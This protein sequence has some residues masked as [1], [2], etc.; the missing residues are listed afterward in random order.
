VRESERE[1]AR[2][3][4]RESQHSACTPHD[5]HGST[6]QAMAQQL[7]DLHIK[8]VWTQDDGTPP[9]FVNQLLFRV[10]TVSIIRIDNVI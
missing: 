6:M 3:R 2:Y 1:R 8:P 4:A 9:Y 10:D 5:A 7:L